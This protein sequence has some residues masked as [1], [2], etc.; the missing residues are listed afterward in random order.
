MR[1]RTR[2]GM[3]TK[4]DYATGTSARSPLNRDCPRCH[5]GAGQ[6][7]WKLTETPYPQHITG[8][9]A[10]RRAPSGPKGSSDPGPRTPNA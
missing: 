4:Y 6:R 2:A 3:R 7:C 10:E 5:A 9:H 1:P 8:Y